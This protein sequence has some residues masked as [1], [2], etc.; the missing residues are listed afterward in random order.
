MIQIE[1]LSSHPDLANT[2]FIVSFRMVFAELRFH[3]IFRL[4]DKFFEIFFLHI[5]AHNTIRLC[6][7][8]MR[9]DVSTKAAETELHKQTHEKEIYNAKKQQKER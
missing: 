2:F 8:R 5:T 1:I 9:S 6:L 3:H 4:I 7:N